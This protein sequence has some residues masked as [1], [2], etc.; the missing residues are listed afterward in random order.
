[1]QDLYN[2]I[3]SA[4]KDGLPLTEIKPNIKDFINQSVITHLYSNAKYSLGKYNRIKMSDYSNELFE[5]ILICWDK[6]SNTKIHDHPDGGCILH[7]INGELEE[8]LYDKQLS[9]ITITKVVPG[10]SS[11]M[12]NS[13]GY[14]KI[15]SPDYSMSLHI[16]SPPNHKMKIMSET[17]V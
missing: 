8:H 4:I 12:D 7:L 5:I 1:M 11:Y 17:N 6:D 16:Y 9:L 10:M 14:H 13:I 15:K 3:N 2:Y